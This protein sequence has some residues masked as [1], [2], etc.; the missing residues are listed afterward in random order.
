MDAVLAGQG[1]EKLVRTA[2]ET[3]PASGAVDAALE[4]AR[5]HARQGRKALALLP[6]GDPRQT[7]L[8][9]IEYAVKRKH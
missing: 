4:E 5:S 8:A 3:I 9:L 2:I 6:D 7:L 1:D